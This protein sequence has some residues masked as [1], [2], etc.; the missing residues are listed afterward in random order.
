MVLTVKV[1]LF[2]IVPLSCFPKARP[3]KVFDCESPRVTYTPIDLTAPQHC[4]DP[5]NDFEDPVPQRVQILQTDT[6]VPMMGYQCL[7]T[8]TKHVV[9]CGFTHIT[10]ADSWP[11]FDKQV[12]ILP[13]ECREAVQKGYIIIEKRKY[14][15]QV[16]TSQQFNFFSHG[17]VNN[18]KC[19]TED[20][21]SEG[22]VFY[23]SYEKVH[24]DITI[25]VIRGYVNT[26]DNLVTFEGRH[27]GLITRYMDGVVRDHFAGTIVWNA[28]IPKCHETVSQVYL[29][30]AQ[31]HKRKGGDA[32]ESVVMVQNE[33][34][35]QYAGLVLRE[36]QSVCQ[37]HCYSTQAKGLMVCLL[38]EMDAA[39]PEA[40]FRSS[41]KPQQ[42]NLQSQ[43]G[44][45]HVDTNLK[46]GSRFEQVQRD[47]CDLD[48]RIL[49]NK[50]Q[51]IAGTRNPY[52]MMD[53]Y[54]PG[55]AIYTSG[56]TAYLTKCEA[57]EATRVEFANCTEEVPVRVNGTVK[58][59]DAFTLILRE[60]PTIIPCSD[61]FPVMWFLGG[62]WYCATPVARRCDAPLQLNTTVSTFTPLGDFTHS[63]G[64]GV[65]T[66]D[67]LNQ[68]AKYQR[69]FHARLPV[70]SK[71][72][73]DAVSRSRGT[74]LGMPLGD[75][76]LSSLTYTVGSEVFPMFAFFGSAWHALS[77]FLLICILGK[78]LAGCMWR[79]WVLYKERGFGIWMLGALWSTAFSIL[80]A[81]VDL[82][83]SAVDTIKKPLHQQDALFRM[84]DS[85]DDDGTAQRPR[86]SLYPN[87]FKKLRSK[88]TGSRAA[89]AMEMSTMT[90]RPTATAPT[91]QEEETVGLMPPAMKA[92]DFKASGFNAASNDARF[93]RNMSMAQGAP[94]IEDERGRPAGGGELTKRT[95]GAVPKASPRPRPAD[96]G[97]LGP[98]PFSGYA[99]GGKATTKGPESADAAS[100]RD[101]EMTTLSFANEKKP[102]KRGDE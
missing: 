99:G 34:T 21:L 31:L 8:V 36:P 4:A 12:E 39:I 64:R 13:N 90:R 59:A 85:S 63:L 62:K 93:W 22:M 82:V 24:L 76:D 15:V 97:P 70:L 1:W 47:L 10:Y 78:L 79:G 49:S 42:A 92:T 89:E 43:M 48:R 14:E 72:T 91:V 18:G 16:G 11:A 73:H 7:A 35:M 28:T 37:V 45:L 9:P 26:A 50:L 96:L 81:P 83:R 100:D 74:S 55:Y 19:E 38:R 44:F 87:L 60:F 46:M 41:F 66:D 57:V 2:L 6:S 3:F 95:T 30:D 5:V 25:D 29:G 67:Q 33:E 101:R 68:H 102:A 52:A 58:F 98:P 75:E 56:A 17:S 65:F 53:I 71:V 88:S 77:T 20:F 86:R 27:S 32:L 61:V 54:G 69:A 51:A 80:R 84:D 94:F 23:A 40:S